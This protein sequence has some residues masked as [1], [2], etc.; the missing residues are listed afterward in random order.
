MLSHDLEHQL[1]SKE[2]EL[3]RLFQK[4][5][6]VRAALFLSSTQQPR[7]AGLQASRVSPPLPSSW[8]CSAA[9]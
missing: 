2:N 9:S 5:K 3:E 6:T 8:S 1:S 4:Q 7:E